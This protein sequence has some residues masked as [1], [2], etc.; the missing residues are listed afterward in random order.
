MADAADPADV[1]DHLLAR[2]EGLQRRIGRELPQHLSTETEGLRGTF[3]RTLGLL[4]SE[5]ARP[6]QLARGTN[7]TKQAM[8]ERLAEMAERGWIA[9]EPDPADGRARIVRRTPEGDRVRAL[10]EQAIASVEASFA[11]EVGDER[12]ATFLEVLAELADEL[13]LR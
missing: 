13:D 6:S 2:L 10:T 11:E 5:G 9:I 12:Y 8:G 4:P 1:P 3:G 7:I